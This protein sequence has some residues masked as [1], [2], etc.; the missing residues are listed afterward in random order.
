MGVRVVFLLNCPLVLS[1]HKHKG[2]RIF[3]NKKKMRFSN[4][5]SPL[6]NTSIDKTITPI[7]LNNNSNLITNDDEIR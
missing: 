1:L 4:R 5:K 3:L 6:N 7:L 2:V